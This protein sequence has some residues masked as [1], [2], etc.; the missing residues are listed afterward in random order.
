MPRYDH[1]SNPRLFRIAGPFS[2]ISGGVVVHDPLFLQGKDPWI[3]RDD[4]D[5]QTGSSN[6]VTPNFG[7]FN[8]LRLLSVVV[9]TRSSGCSDSRASP[10]SM[11]LP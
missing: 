6:A 9:A 5:R 10:S 7:G 11:I 8:S 1:G 3:D 4:P 2:R